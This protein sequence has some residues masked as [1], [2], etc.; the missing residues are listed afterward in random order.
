MKYAWIEND[1]IRD[2]TPTDPFNWHHP[3]IAKFYDT[4]VPDEAKNGDFWKD[5][6]LVAYVI[7]EPVE[8]EPLPRTINSSDIRNGLTLAEKSKWD[9]DST[10]EIITAKLELST[11]K[12]VSDTTEILQ[13]LVDSGSISQTSM[14]KVLA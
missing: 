4:Q 11:P 3:D 10:P 1:R 9:N 5:G 2:L 7:P 13:F 12:S 6:K 14:D 8:P